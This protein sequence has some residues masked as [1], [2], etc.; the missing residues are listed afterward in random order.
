MYACPYTLYWSW[1]GDGDGAVAWGLD[2][3]RDVDS[4][5]DSS[6]NDEG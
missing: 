1:T 5:S 6:S 4:M 2:L 3:Y